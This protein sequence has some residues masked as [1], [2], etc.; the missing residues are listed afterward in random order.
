MSADMFGFED[1]TAQR[2]NYRPEAAALVETALSGQ[3]LQA[4]ASV[5]IKGDGANIPDAAAALAKP[6][7]R[8]REPHKWAG[9]LSGSVG[10]AALTLSECSRMAACWLWRSKRHP[11]S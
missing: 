7:A 11:G 3:K 1:A 8:T 9:G 4:A 6:D 2:T 5:A 10:V